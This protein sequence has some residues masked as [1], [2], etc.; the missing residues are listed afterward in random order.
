[1]ASE[2]GGF[3]SR[4]ASLHHVSGRCSA[5]VRSGRVRPGGMSPTRS[6]FNFGISTLSK[7]YVLASVLMS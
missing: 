6:P 3:S 5:S 7:G 4:E 1:M 2:S